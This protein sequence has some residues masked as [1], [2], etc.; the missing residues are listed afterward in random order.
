MHH[1]APGMR[2]YL[3]E[4][5]DRLQAAEP[6]V[7]VAALGPLMLRVAAELGDGVALNWC[8]AAQV[9]RS[10]QAVA[11]SA[12]GATRPAPPLMEYIRVCV[13][14]D[15]AAAR[16]ALAL[17]MLRYALGP[18]GYR[19]HFGRMGFEAQ[20]AELEAKREAG[21]SEPELA[22]SCP[23]DLL[24]AAGG[25]GRPGEVRE[26]F[27]R[28]AAGLDEAVVRVVLAR[29]GDAAGVETT[30]REFAPEGG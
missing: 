15:V 25:Y 10:R 27:E 21:A 17:A 4:L 19:K 12:A 20:L 14:R 13:D 7:Y 5:K 1:P 11:E 18:A 8:S 6:P 9:E 28:L 30:L 29:T 2:A 16:R 22:D 3:G 24:R 23:E 26:Q